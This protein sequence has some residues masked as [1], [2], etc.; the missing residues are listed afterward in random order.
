MMASVVVV[1]VGGVGVML[2]AKSKGWAGACQMIGG[3][4]LLVWL[5]TSYVAI[6]NP[7]Q[8]E[9]M[10]VSTEATTLSVPA[11][12]HP[13][14]TVPTNRHSDLAVAS[15]LSAFFL[16]PAGGTGLM[17]YAKSRGWAGACQMIGGIILAVWLYTCYISL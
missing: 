10:A 1:P 2:C 13:M 8:E 3:V 6:E 15:I 7:V 9:P 12:A 5:W 17:L 4:I 11:M 16:V 14:R